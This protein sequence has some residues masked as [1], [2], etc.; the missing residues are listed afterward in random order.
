MK[1]RTK[2]SIIFI[3]ILLMLS[4]VAFTFAKKIS[5]EFQNFWNSKES[6]EYAKINDVIVTETKDGIKDWELYAATAEY[7]NDKVTAKLTD[8]VGN[9][10]QDNEVVMSFTAPTGLY[11]SVKKEISLNDSVKIVGKEDTKLTANRIYWVTTEDKIHA[12]GDVIINK[13][14]E[15]IA[16][17][18]KAA[19][20]T[21]L[22]FFEISE[23]TELRVY[24][25]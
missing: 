1:K 5:N 24:K 10:Y 25:K 7:D 6:L 15:V 23:N 12:E 9:Y 4:I 21:D 17:S 19:V 18:D 14:N 3:I 8:I 22:K 20:S 16:L 13:G 2:F 11:D